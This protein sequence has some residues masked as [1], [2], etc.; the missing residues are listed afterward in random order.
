MTE[1]NVPKWY[2]FGSVIAMLTLIVLTVIG[3][4]ITGLDGLR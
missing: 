2:W 3:E 4:T 1:G